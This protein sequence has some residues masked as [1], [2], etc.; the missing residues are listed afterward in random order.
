MICELENI[1]K[2]SIQ[3][4]AQREKL[5]YEKMK[6]PHS[7]GEKNQAANGVTGDLE[8]KKKG[9]VEKSIKNNLNNGLEF[10]KFNEISKLKTQETH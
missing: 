10:C 8:E 4:E 9:N 3:I 5:K 6:D 1:A 7:H 2:E